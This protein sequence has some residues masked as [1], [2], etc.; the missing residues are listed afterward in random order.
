MSFGNS[1]REL[2]ERARF[3]FKLELS[4][5]KQQVERLKATAQFSRFLLT[6]KTSL[7]H[8]LILG[9]TGSGKT[10]HAFDLI[11]RTMKE[12]PSVSCVVVDGKREYRK[13]GKLL[14]GKVDVLSIGGEPKARFNPLSPPDETDAAHWD[15]AFADVFT[16]AYGLSE[17]SRR[18]L[19][20]SLFELRQES[21]ES[22]TLRELEKKVAEFEAGSPGEHGSR[23]SLESRLHIINTGPV[24]ES[25]NAEA[26]LDIDSFD[27][28]VVVFEIGEVD[29]LRD[30]A[31]IAELILLYLWQHDRAFVDEDEERLKRLVVVEEAQGTSAKK[32]LRRGEG[33]GRS[34]NWRWLK[35]GATDGVS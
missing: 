24:G 22:P 4:E 3:N 30:Q 32:G 5:F 23:R 33:R 21:K 29:S 25:L 27:E 15:R 8:V 11:I 10:N 7:R 1:P 28:K 20:D 31:F 17:P 34:L 9:S 12:N 35:P 26:E 18:I 6:E 16:R 19:L 14:E 13:L 2:E